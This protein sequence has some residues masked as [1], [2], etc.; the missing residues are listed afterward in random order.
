V[1]NSRR[2][3]GKHRKVESPILS[4]GVRKELLNVKELRQSSKINKVPR[5][6]TTKYRQ[7][8]VNRKF[9]A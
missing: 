3:F 2:H 7:Y 9:P 8:L 5:F 6:C 4:D 1:T